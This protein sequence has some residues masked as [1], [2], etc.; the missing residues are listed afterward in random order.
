MKQLLNNE[1]MTFLEYLQGG[2][3]PV[4]KEKWII[5]KGQIE[6]ATMT[7]YINMER[8]LCGY[9]GDNSLAVSVRF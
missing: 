9:Y 7:D 6:Q 1:E 4:G 5:L 3:L 2:V 8:H